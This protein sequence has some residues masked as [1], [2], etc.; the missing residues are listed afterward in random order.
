MNLVSDDRS[1]IILVRTRTC[2]ET[3]AGTDNNR[4]TGGAD[5]PNQMA[6][7]RFAGLIKARVRHLQSPRVDSGRHH[8]YA[9]RRVLDY[10][11]DLTPVINP[12]LR[13]RR[14]SVSE[15]SHAMIVCV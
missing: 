11:S 9:H 7:G 8:C 2:A 4:G 6:R 5:S 3:Q 1:S 15:R 14:N 10:R 13:G 12:E